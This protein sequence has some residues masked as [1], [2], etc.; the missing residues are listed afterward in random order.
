MS[1]MV[2]GNGVRRF[3]PRKLTGEHLRPFSS[4]CPD[5]LWAPG[6][7]PLRRDRIEEDGVGLHSFASS[8]HL[9]QNAGMAEPCPTRLR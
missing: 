7:S 4:R 3:G 6:D 9:H 5:H 8:R 2:H 1:A